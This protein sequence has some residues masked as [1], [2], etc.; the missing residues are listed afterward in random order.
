LSADLGLDQVLAYRL[1]L[2]HGKLTPN[3]SQPFLTLPPGSGPRHFAFHPNGRHLYVINE[4]SNTILA[5]D[6]DGD[7][8]FTVIQ[9]LST[10]PQGFT[11]TSYC[12]EIVVSPSGATLYGSNRG[13]DSIAIFDIDANSGL[14]SFK[15]CESTRGKN[16]RNFALDPDGKLL[17]VANQNSNE[18]VIFRIDPLTGDLAPT[19]K[20]I[21]S[22][23]PSCVK[24]FRATR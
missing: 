22:P 2:P 3:E 15:A 16:P 10:L 4:L 6:Y 17:F 20:T 18:T 1:D 21:E 12:A 8:G 7:G 19:G 5:W 9:R 13:H 14:L 11:G 24:F 23:S